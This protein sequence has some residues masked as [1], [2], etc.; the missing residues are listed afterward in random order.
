MNKLDIENFSVTEISEKECIKTNAG[1]NL[2]WLV[3]YIVGVVD[4]LNDA[5]NDGIPDGRIGAR[6]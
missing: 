6:R 4:N 1:S 3:G 5:Y 2:S